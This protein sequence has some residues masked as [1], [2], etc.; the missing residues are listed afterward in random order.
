MNKNHNMFKD[1]HLFKL[2]DR[3][4]QVQIYMPE[5]VCHK[6]KSP[7]IIFELFSIK[8]TICVWFLSLAIDFILSTILS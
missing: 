3:L 6:T 5:N 2:I 8:H 1:E 4:P 7:C